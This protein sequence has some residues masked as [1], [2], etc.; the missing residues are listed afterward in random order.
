MAGRLPEDFAGHGGGSGFRLPAVRAAL[1]HRCRVCR[2]DL[3][4]TVHGVMHLAWVDRATA[5]IKT[6]GRLRQAT[7]VCSGRD[8]WRLDQAVPVFDCLT[9]R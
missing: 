5:A 8:N 3:N 9:P 7:A 4:K 6:D 2:G 1:S